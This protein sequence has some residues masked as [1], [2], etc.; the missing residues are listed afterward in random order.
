MVSLVA[1]TRIAQVVW[2]NEF[3]VR[4]L[5]PIYIP[6]SIPA[7]LTLVENRDD[8]RIEI[9]LNVPDSYTYRYVGVVN[10]YPYDEY[11]YEIV[12]Q[13][14]NQPDFEGTVGSSTDFNSVNPLFIPEVTPD[15]ELSSWYYF[16]LFVIFETTGEYVRLSKSVNYEAYPVLSTTRLYTTTDYTVSVDLALQVNYPHYQYE[17][18]GRVSEDPL[19]DLVITNL[20]DKQESN[21]EGTFVQGENTTTGQT[22]TD[23]NQDPLGITFYVYLM[24]R[25][26]QKTVLQSAWVETRIKQVVLDN[27]FTIKEITPDYVPLETTGTLT[28]AEN[29]PD[30]QIDVVLDMQHIDDSYTYFGTVRKYPYPAYDFETAQSILTHPDFQG[31]ATTNT[32]FTISDPLTIPEQVPGS[33]I[34]KDYYVTLFA[35]STVT[36]EYIRRSEVVFYDALPLMYIDGFDTTNY[37]VSVDLRIDHLVPYYQYEYAGRVSEDPLTDLVMT[38]LFDNQESNIEGT[39]VQGAT[40]AVGTTK[41]DINQDPLGTTFYVY[42]FTRPIVHPELV[43]MITETRIKQVIL[44]NQF[45]VKELEPEYVPL[46]TAG[47]LTLTE[48]KADRRIDVSLT[49]T[50]I[51]TSY[52]RGKSLEIEKLFMKHIVTA[53]TPLAASSLTDSLAESKSRSQ[54]IVPSAAVRSSISMVQSKGAS[55]GVFL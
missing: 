8:E 42:M 13:I 35:R 28:L 15:T 12:T 10:K 17:Y 37:T 27:Q 21:I 7:V 45:T 4:T 19:T 47:I 30:Q 22:N 54:T 11:T 48:N 38:N 6:L 9:N 16:S 53:S 3:T 18:A 36:G 40:T 1:E 2:N 34:T 41:A 44:D 31:T 46:E 51:D 33:D 52:T 32:T 25:A 39:F 29:K 50:N 23:I 26:I 5:N 20:F 24:A 43:S 14:V 49:M 55:G